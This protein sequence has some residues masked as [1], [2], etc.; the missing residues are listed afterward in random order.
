MRHGLCSGHGAQGKEGLDYLALVGGEQREDLWVDE[1]QLS[2][3]LVAAW[4]VH[5]RGAFIEHQVLSPRPKSVRG[6]RCTTAS[7]PHVYS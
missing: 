4:V 2:L 3:D 5:S 1:V 7:A 6:Q